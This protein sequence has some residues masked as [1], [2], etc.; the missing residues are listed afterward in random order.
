M[1]SRIGSESR[2]LIGLAVAGLT[3]WL[4]SRWLMT[5]TSLD[6]EWISVVERIGRGVGWVS[7]SAI[8]VIASVRSRVGFGGAGQPQ[9]MLC[10]SAAWAILAGICLL[11]SI[12]T[13]ELLPKSPLLFVFATALLGVVVT[14]AAAWVL[15]HSRQ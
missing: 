5:N 10:K 8:L 3:A 9:M 14:G 2:I 7:F 12:L 6:G 13:P 1:A 11:F 15:W 4:T